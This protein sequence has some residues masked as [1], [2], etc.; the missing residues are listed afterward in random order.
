[1]SGIEALALEENESDYM[2]YRL[3]YAFIKV[4]IS[5]LHI[6]EAQLYLHSPYSFMAC[7]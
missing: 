1:L 5:L 7:D 4:K 2:Q 6:M 3:S